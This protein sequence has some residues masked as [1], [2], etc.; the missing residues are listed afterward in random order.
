[1]PIHFNKDAKAIQWNNGIARSKKKKTRQNW[2]LT[3]YTK[4][5]QFKMGR[6]SNSQSNL[7]KE[8]RAGGTRCSDF[9]LHYRATVS[10]RAC[11]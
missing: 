8:H 6:T 7:E 11:Y 4:N 1:M 9:R 3:P 5:Y 2:T 10:K